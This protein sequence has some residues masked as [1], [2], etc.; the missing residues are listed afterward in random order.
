VEGPDD[1][2]EGETFLLVMAVRRNR[3]FRGG[4]EDSRGRESLLPDHVEPKGDEVSKTTD[5]EGSRLFVDLGREGKKESVTW[6]EKGERERM[7]RTHL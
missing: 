5:V 4:S 6:K 7:H 1:V 2:S 3:S